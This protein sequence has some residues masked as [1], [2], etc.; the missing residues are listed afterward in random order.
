MSDTTD[1]SPEYI[2][3]LKILTA[4]TRIAMDGYL[5]YEIITKQPQSNVKLALLITSIVILYVTAAL[6][7]WR[8]RH[9]LRDTLVIG[10]IASNRHTV[11]QM[12]QEAQSE[13]DHQDHEVVTFSQNLSYLT[14]PV[15]IIENEEQTE[16]HSAPPP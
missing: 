4:L 3:V 9:K 16:W 15:G 2:R 6:L 10:V 1:R 11:V 13:T 12:I 8:A 7:L 5:L 14:D